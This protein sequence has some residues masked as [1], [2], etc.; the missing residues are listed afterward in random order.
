MGNKV[1]LPEEYNISNSFKIG[2]LVL[3]EG[4]TSMRS[5]IPKEGGVELNVH[6][7]SLT[8]PQ[9]QDQEGAKSN[10]ESQGK[11]CRTDLETEVRKQKSL[12]VSRPC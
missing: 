8:T 9:D 1:N 3:Y 6:G 12:F 2:D 5:I 4:N 10:Q 11:T 7:L